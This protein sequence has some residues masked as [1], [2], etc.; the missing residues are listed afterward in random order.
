MKS[1]ARDGDSDGRHGSVPSISVSPAAARLVGPA[2]K[3]AGS[4]TGRSV[5]A[6]AGDCRPAPRQLLVRLRGGG[7]AGEDAGVRDPAGPVPRH[8][9]LRRRL[10]VP[11][12]GSGGVRVPAPARERSTPSSGPAS[13]WWRPVS[14]CCS[15]CRSWSTSSP[16]PRSR[17]G[18][19]CPYVRSR[20]RC[21]AERP[22]LTR[23]PDTPGKDFAI[24]G[25]GPL[26]TLLIAA[27]GLGRAADR[28][29]RRPRLHRAAPAHLVQRDRRH[30]QP[31]ARAPARRRQHAGRRRLEGHRQRAARAGRRGLGRS[32]GRGPDRRHARSCSGCARAS[33]PARSSSSGRR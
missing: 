2:E 7:G 31:A 10:A 21:S 12:R 26:A 28:A 27:L 23:K 13:S 11:D 20:C 1:P 32:R 17:A 14:R 15:T 18:S 4:R 22:S 19:G 29:G 5:R 8:P 6:H 25:A 16:T 3:A 24:S 30:L 33:R 9:D